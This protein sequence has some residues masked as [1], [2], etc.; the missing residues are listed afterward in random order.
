MGKIFSFLKRQV[1][2][3][4]VG[5]QSVFTLKIT[6]AWSKLILWALAEFAISIKIDWV[7][8][9]EYYGDKLMVRYRYLQSLASQGSELKALE[10]Q[11]QHLL[12]KFLEFSPNLENY[13]SWKR[14]FLENLDLCA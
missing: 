3:I 7:E 2:Q 8:A 14:A 1:D 6:R 12:K 9:Y 11:I 4:K 13:E 10:I 5:G